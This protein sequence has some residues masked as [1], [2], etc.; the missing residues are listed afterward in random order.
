MKFYDFYK[1]YGIYLIMLVVFVFFSIMSPIFFTTANL[2]NI[3]RQVSMFGIVVVG[4][5][6][7]TISGG[8]D[9]SVGGQM[10]V[11]GMIAATLM[12]KF[13]VP[14]VFAV[15]ISMAVG[16]MLGIING[17][18]AIKLNIFPMIVTLGTMLILNGLAFLV[19]GGYPIFG[20][21]EAFKFLGQGYAK[22]IPVPV[23]IF[24]V[25]VAFGVVLLNK[26]YFGR[27]I[28][29]MGGNPNAAHL[30]GI[31]VNR[32]RVGVYALCGFLTSIASLIMLSRTNSAQPAAGSSYPF[33]CMTAICLG[34][35]SVM[36]GTGSISGAIVGVLI[37]GV[38]NNGLQL[39]NCDINLVSVIKGIILIIAVGIDCVQKTPKKGKVS[40]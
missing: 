19:S 34:G 29:A 7:V 24:I 2:L 25:V 39:L 22:F 16:I 4:V 11:I 38:L 6:L 20:L 26:T 3:L 5:S 17:L 35:V 13:N 12:V 23:I 32:M 9:L 37:I 8:A 28:Y 36:G 14:I 15:F 40:V 31:N 18:I 1:K 10:A 33:D 30:A 27:F 21:P